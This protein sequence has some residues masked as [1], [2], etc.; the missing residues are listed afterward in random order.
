L[1]VEFLVKRRRPLAP[2]LAPGRANSS[3]TTP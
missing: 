2:I 3:G 1:T